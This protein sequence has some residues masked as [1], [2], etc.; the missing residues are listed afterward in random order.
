MGGI[1]WNWC[2]TVEL[3]VWIDKLE[4]IKKIA[5]FVALVTS[6]IIVL[7]SRASTLSITICKEGLVFLTV[8]LRSCPLLKVA[9]LMKLREDILCYYC[10]LFCR[11]PPEVVKSNFEPVIY[12]FV[13]LVVFIAEFFGCLAR[14]EC[15][16]L[17]CCTVLIYAKGT[18]LT[19]GNALVIKILFLPFSGRILFGSVMLTILWSRGMLL[20]FKYLLEQG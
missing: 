18:L 14:L 15:F 11:S 16:R 5:A 12:F 8:W 13:F 10:L 6:S 9:I 17:R 4:W 1:S 2:C 3:T 19:Y 20:E 7:T